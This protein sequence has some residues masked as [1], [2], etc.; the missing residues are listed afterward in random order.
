MTE[1]GGRLGKY[2]LRGTLGRG[3]MG[4]VYD[5]WDPVIARRVAVKTVKVPDPTDAEAMEEL[6][7]F[8][9][10]AQAAGRLTHPNIVGVYDYG[11]DGNIAY[12]VMEFVEGPTLKSLLEKQERMALPDVAR[13][14][15]DLLTGLAFSHARGIVHRDIKPAN[16]M[17]TLEGRAKIA[18]FGIARIE[19]SSMTQAGTVMG[20]PAYMSPEQFMG[21][22]VDAR[23]DIYSSGVLLYQLLTGE[24]PFEGGMTA[25]MHKALNT[26]P[27]KPSELSVTAPPALDAV[28]ARAMAKR[29]EGRWPNAEAFAAAIRQAL[30]APAAGAEPG[31]DATMISAPSA[32]PPPGSRAAPRA[33]PNPA[34]TPPAAPA[35]KGSP[36]V[37]I[38]GGVVALAAIGGGA[39]FFLLG[40]EAPPVPV[41]VASV[42]AI[43]TPAATPVAAPPVTPMPVPAPPTVPSL[44]PATAAPATPAPSVPPLAVLQPAPAPAMPAPSPT[45]PSPTAP[46]PPAPSPSVQP[47][48]VAPAPAVQAP[49][50]QPAPVV[51]APT[52]QPPPTPAPTPAPLPPQNLALAPVTPPPVPSAPQPAALPSA[53]SV[54][55]A[56]ASALPPLSCSLVSGTATDQRVTLR[57]VVGLGA[58]E[59]ALRDAVTAAAGQV[60]IDWRVNG[61]DA[62]FCLALDALRPAA[63]PFGTQGALSVALAG[64]TTRLRDGELVTVVVNG[65][66]FPAYLHVSFLV[67][68]GTL[69]HLHPT[70]S[71]PQR[72]LPARG[73]LRLGDPSIGGPAW[74]VSPPYGTDLIIAVA[75][76][77]PLFDRARPEDEDLGA[78]LRGLRA[79]LDEA[80]R[81]GARVAADAWVLETAAR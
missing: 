25:I 19:S 30:A 60:P 67:H 6:A 26:D 74:A 12:I 41:P 76:S 35:R 59:R 20:T 53:A 63:Q 24:R 46:L 65:P 11:E 7:R 71:D 55:A 22:T 2:E 47:Q 48:P 77:V 16:V 13:V 72:L 33:A 23:T 50:V 52:A 69:A 62:P 66:D 5:G 73:T 38:A 10:E 29:P 8:R 45:A 14:M 81:R 31:S 1:P 18:D 56:L 28:V 9:R 36:V 54:R 42:P 78:F 64:N 27:P 37:P 32:G 39:A 75:S 17:L 3:A 40:G 70:P 43:S 4:V 58:P 51:Q 68:D 21:Q 34:A 44:P 57:G 15:E 80:R 61:F 79:A 49:P